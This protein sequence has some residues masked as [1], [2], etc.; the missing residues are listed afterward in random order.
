MSKRKA[1]EIRSLVL[2]VMLEAEKTGQYE[3]D[4]VKAVLKKYDYLEARD[5]AFLKRLAEG[6]TERRISLDYLLDQ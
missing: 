2:D 1:D 3:S 6:C 5:K 4:L